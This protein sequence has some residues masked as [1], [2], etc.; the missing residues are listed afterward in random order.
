M[1]KE[2]IPLKQSIDLKKL[3]FN[4]PV[5]G[6]F[7][8]KEFKLS[9]VPFNANKDHGDFMSLATQSA[10]LYQQVFRWFREKYNIDTLPSKTYNYYFH[11][12]INDEL[13]E[14]ENGLKPFL[15]GK[16]Y[17]EAEFECLKKLIEIVNGI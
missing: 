8:E 14:N 16:T 7:S 9:D 2:F 6:Y 13:F 5:I 4:E 3:G 15:E 17:E 11:I 10:P 1:K 12:Y